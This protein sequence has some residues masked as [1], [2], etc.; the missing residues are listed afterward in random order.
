MPLPKPAFFQSDKRP[1]W[2]SALAG[3]AVGL[4]L[5]FRKNPGFTMATAAGSIGLLL[6]LFLLLSGGLSRFSKSAD[7]EVPE[8]AG[9]LGEQ[10]ES[11]ADKKLKET[12]KEVEKDNSTLASLEGNRP[13]R[14]SPR[15]E[16][17]PP[18][19]PRSR[20]ES[21]LNDHEPSDA[22]S[23]DS[24]VSRA[25]DS[26]ST[27]LEEEEPAGDPF[28]TVG[29]TASR[30]VKEE[31]PEEEPISQPLKPI[32]NSASIAGL[33]GDV[34][35]EDEAETD[36]S[37]ATAP[38]DDSRSPLIEEETTEDETE[39]AVKEEPIAPKVIK[40]AKNPERLF[41]DDEPL[42]GSSE[43]EPQ[44]ASRPTTTTIVKTPVKS[45]PP[46]PPIGDADD[47][48]FVPPQ[49]KPEESGSST[50]SP[51]SKSGWKYS[52]TKPQVPPRESTGRSQAV[53]TAVYAAPE[54]TPATAAPKRVPD[55]A[56]SREI[57][58]VEKKANAPLALTIKAPR[59]VSPGQAF[60]IEFTVTN[61]SRETVRGVILSV[62][63]P[64]GLSHDLGPELE[65]PIETL[66]AGQTHR[67][68]LR[69]KATGAGDITPRADVAIKGQPRITSTTTLR[70][71]ST[72][73]SSTSTIPPCACEPDV[74]YVW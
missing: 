22:D 10:G 67:A 21:F 55:P 44:P 33:H 15:R 61:T 53:E 59:N 16:A 8:V 30:D 52:T 19:R 49:S 64:A 25:N 23:T 31:E 51:Q 63:L 11:L 65:Q 57:P 24:V 56:P 58:P 18:E 5:R 40:P 62:L 41:S 43:E 20:D 39:V 2:R 32:T 4:R 36:D 28:D 13:H 38:K 74:R 68:R 69:V 45:S 70:V 6:A 12:K 14:P 66:T 3:L 48:S 1:Q 50:T 71:G 60:D 17:S 73:G 34:E 72:G 7:D 9:D 47:G 27:K 42:G 54:S 37:I 35:E 26:R 29:M 46:V